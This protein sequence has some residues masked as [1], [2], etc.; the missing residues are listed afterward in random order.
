MRQLRGAQGST[1]NNNKR[2]ADVMGGQEDTPSLELRLKGVSDAIN[3]VSF[4]SGGR[5]VAAAGADK[6]VVVWNLDTGAAEDASSSKESK[7][8][9]K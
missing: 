1:P 3:H 4:E 9:Y 7:Q 5:Q 2:T 8:A 6:T